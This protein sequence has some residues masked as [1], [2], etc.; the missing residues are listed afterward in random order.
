MA[1]GGVVW[2]SATRIT[3]TQWTAWTL[4]YATCTA[5]SDPSASRSTACWD[6]V[7]FLQSDPCTESNGLLSTTESPASNHLHELRSPVEGN[8]WKCDG[9]VWFG[10]DLRLESKNNCILY[11]AFLTSGHSKSFTT[12]PVESTPQGNSLLV[13]SGQGEASR[14]G[15]PPHS[16]LSS[17]S[18]WN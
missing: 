1:V 18:Q 13:R 17:R 15:T 11:C 5:S 4:A 14:S 12:L 6:A 8:G 3:P 10:L 16:L 7:L 9:I 2:R